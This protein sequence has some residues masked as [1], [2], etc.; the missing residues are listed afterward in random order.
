MAWRMSAPATTRA[1]FTELVG[2]GDDGIDLAEATLLI[3][4]EAYPG[5]DITRYM[6]ALDELAAEAERAVGATGSDA[7]RVRK[8]VEFLSIQRQFRGNQDDYYDRRNSF[9]NEV[10]ERRTG[11]P[12]TLAVV[13]MEVARRLGLVLH[14]VGFPGHFLAKHP[15]ASPELI[16]DPFFG[17]I[18][19]ARDCAERLRAVLG[20]HAKLEPGHLRAA[21]PK[22]ILV[23]IL[24]NLKQIYLQARELEPALSCSER[25]L[26]IEPELAHELRDRGLL[27]EQLECF[28]AARGDLERFLALAPEDP[29]AATIR[30]RL[31]DL[32]RHGATLH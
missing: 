2:S 7:E 28:A 6:R 32:G 15:G 18:L 20:D 22:E 3:A 17:Q 11:I 30:E 27:Y 24:R 23:R 8:L 16:I 31:I 26:L 4:A 5:L 14:G 29:S 12:I 19:S 1:R 10:I 21:T 25:I 13:Y 9:L